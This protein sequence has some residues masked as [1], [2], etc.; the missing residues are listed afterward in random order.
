MNHLKKI[1]NSKTWCFITGKDR[2]I[3]R[4][5]RGIFKTRESDEQRVSFEVGMI[6]GTMT[7]LGISLYFLDPKAAPNSSN[8]VTAVMWPELSEALE[9]S[10]YNQPDGGESTVK[11]LN[12]IT[13]ST[14]R[15]VFTVL[16]GF[17]MFRS[18]RRYWSRRWGDMEWQRSVIYMPWTS[19]VGLAMYLPL[20][21][22]IP[23]FTLGYTYVNMPHYKEW[24]NGGFREIPSKMWNSLYYLTYSWILCAFTMCYAVLPC[25]TIGARGCVWWA[26]R[27]SSGI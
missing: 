5:G 21:V 3:T 11:R 24:V 23:C 9:D 16:M 1:S 7:S 19:S 15:K 25:T 22:S 18:S 6:M 12:E 26:A 4:K 2:D 8:G 13:F 17:A 27:R 20:F 10:V 14:E